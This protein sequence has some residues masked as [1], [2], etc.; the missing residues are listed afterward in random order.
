VT[1][2]VGK[3]CN[4]LF[5]F[6]LL[7]QGV[8]DDDV[9]LP[10]QTEE[11]S[12]AVRASLA[13]IDNMKLFKREVQAG[14]QPL[15]A[16]LE[17]SRLQRRELVEQRQNRDWID[18][19]H[20]NLESSAEQPEVV[21]ELVTGLLHNLQET[22]KNWWGKNESQYLRFDNIRNED[23]WCLFIESKFLFQNKCAIDR[24]R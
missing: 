13:A 8:V 12:I 10:W 17:W 22:S 9:L 7:N 2:L 14:S 4:Y 24:S 1:E 18:S 11:V 19:D 21:E 3:D 16:S 23:L 5:G 20:E 6:A 15:N